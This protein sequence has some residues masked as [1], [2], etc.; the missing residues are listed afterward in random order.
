M[1]LLKVVFCC[2]SVVQ[3]NEIKQCKDCYYHSNKK[4]KDWFC[5]PCVCDAV[6]MLDLPLT[7][8]CYSC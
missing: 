2:M 1:K 6:Y 8:F 5:M 3:L 7:V 4:N